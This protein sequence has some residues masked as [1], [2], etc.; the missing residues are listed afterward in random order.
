MS[1]INKVFNR[2]E[3]I[4]STTFKQLGFKEREHLQEWSWMSIGGHKT[5]DRL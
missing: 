4:E 1:I 3:K 5:A 2:I